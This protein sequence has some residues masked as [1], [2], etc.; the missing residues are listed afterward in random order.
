[1][2]DGT[3]DSPKGQSDGHPL[4]TSKHLLPYGV[5]LLTPNKISHSDFTKIKERSEVNTGDILLS[6]I[7]TV[8]IVS[9]IF[10]NSINFAIKN[11]GLFKTS[12]HDKFKF[13]ILCYL[14]SKKTAD[15]I[16]QHLAGTTQK[17][18]SL[19]ELRKLPIIIPDDVA[20]SEFNSIITP[21]I[22]KIVC[23]TEENQKLC[24]LRDTLLQKLMSG[25]L[26]VSDINL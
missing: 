9:Y 17:Y 18:I 2:R 23:L 7:G 16:I 6:M 20:L 19:S 22:E 24:I 26:D 11:V 13:Y 10:Q 21:I 1:M 25:E 12:Q 8:G 14:K 5:D 15:Y 4:V 3:H